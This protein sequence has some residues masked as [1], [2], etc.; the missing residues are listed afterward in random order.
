MQKN[1][2]NDDDDYSYKKKLSYRRE[3]VRRAVYLTI[4]KTF[5][6]TVGLYIEKV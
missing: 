2:V 3:N 4:S 6:L 5:V 1:A